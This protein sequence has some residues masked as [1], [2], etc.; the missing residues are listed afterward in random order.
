MSFD[1]RPY[2]QH[3]EHQARI[4]LAGGCRRVVLYLPTGGGKHP[5]GLRQVAAEPTPEILGWI[6]SRQIAQAKAK[7]KPGTNHASR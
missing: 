3:A 2:R 5:N 1:L 7:Q 6:K 4:A